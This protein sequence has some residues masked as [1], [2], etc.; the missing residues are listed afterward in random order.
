VSK[1]GKF[2]MSGGRETSPTESGFSVV[3]EG[4]DIIE[5]P[6]TPRH[7]RGLSSASD[8]TTP[9]IVVQDTSL[10]VESPVEEG[11]DKSVHLPASEYK[12]MRTGSMSSIG[13]ESIISIKNN[14]KSISRSISM[15]SVRDI[16][17]DA[18][19]LPK[20]QAA[21]ERKKYED[22]VKEIKGRYNREREYLK[23][24]DLYRDMLAIFCSSLDDNM[25]NEGNK[26]NNFYKGFKNIEEF[27]EEELNQRAKK[28]L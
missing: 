18:L 21:F 16:V 23:S 14:I 22:A 5:A 11:P 25:N 13:E 24:F 4:Q 12:R 19:G 6:N 27:V 26:E 28:Y 2:L 20:E 17:V 1:F 7:T 10:I 8:S 9:S 15:E 3:R